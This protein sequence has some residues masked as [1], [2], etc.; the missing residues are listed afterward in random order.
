MPNK[1]TLLVFFTLFSCNAVFAKE[2]VAIPFEA[3][4]DAV[5]KTTLDHMEKQRIT[6]VTRISDEGYVKFEIETDKVEN[7]KDIIAQDIVI[8]SD[9]KIMKLSQQV[10]YFSLPFEQ[11]KE[12]EK[13]YPKIKVDEVESVQVHY[14]D[15]LGTVNG[16]KIK[17]RL[18]ANGAIQETP[19]DPE[20]TMGQ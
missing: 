12:I 7:N 13:R 15:V 19:A 5:K 9:G 18:F 17:F 3:L 2:T 14:S 1:I 11:M 8:S 16:Q 20:K 10:P 6:K 4:P